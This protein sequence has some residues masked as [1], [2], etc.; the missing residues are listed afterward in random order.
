MIFP[1][2]SALKDTRMVINSEP[3]GFNH[4]YKMFSE[5]EQGINTLSPIRLYY[6]EDGNKDGNWVSEKIKNIGEIEFN[7]RYNLIF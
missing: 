1:S 6:W 5:A 2:L 4:F 7:R 3:N